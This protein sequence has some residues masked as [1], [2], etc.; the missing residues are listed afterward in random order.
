MNRGDLSLR[1]WDI[2]FAIYVTADTLMDVALLY[3]SMQGIK[4]M[5][6]CREILEKRYL[7]EPIECINAIV[8]GIAYWQSIKYY[9]DDWLVEYEVSQWIA[10]LNDSIGVAPSYEDVFTHYKSLCSHRCDLDRLYR[11]MECRRKWVQR[12]INKWES[13]RGSISTFEADGNTSVQH[14]VRLLLRRNFLLFF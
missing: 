1:Q 4:N 13:A 6:F 2:A 9:V 8:D 12:F 14:K 10:T 7:A 11:T 3:L 5:Q